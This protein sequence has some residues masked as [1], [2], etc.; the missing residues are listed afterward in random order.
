MVEV[1]KAETDK[2]QTVA[3]D[4]NAHDWHAQASGKIVGI[5]QAKI[6]RTVL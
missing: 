2:P 4:N 3:K 6:A 5:P 1:A